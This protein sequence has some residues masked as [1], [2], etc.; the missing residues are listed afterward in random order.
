M[1]CAKMPDLSFSVVQE[2]HYRA[3]NIFSWRHLTCHGGRYVMKAKGG[4]SVAPHKH[5]HSRISYLYQVASYLSQLQ[6]SRQYQS[7]E[8]LCTLINRESLTEASTT[9][10]LV[11]DTAVLLHHASTRIP[12]VETSQRNS[13]DCAKSSNSG[14]ARHI[15]SH[16]RRIS[17]KSQIRLSR[18]MKHSIC[19]RCEAILIPG[20]TSKAYIENKSRKGKKTW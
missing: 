8:G 2:H 12:H 9:Q 5:I 16:L 3:H 7:K 1:D 13:L 15:L 20:F 14:T 18:G 17:Q 11:A 4:I 10:L 19:R 6:L